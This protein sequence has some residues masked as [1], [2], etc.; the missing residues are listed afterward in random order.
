MHVFPNQVVKIIAPKEANIEYIERFIQSKSRWILK[1]IKVFEDIHGTSRAPLN[2]VSGETIYYLG[3][4]YRIKVVAGEAE[5]KLFQGRLVISVTDKE[6]KEKKE[7]LVES[8]YRKRQKEIFVRRLQYLYPLIAKYEVEFP[9]LRI[10]TM[11]KRWGS[12]STK[13]HRI[14]LNSELIYASTYCIDYVIV[15]E[16]V[17]FIH[18]NHSKQ[19]YEM[20]TLLMPDWK[21]RK[22]KLDQDVIREL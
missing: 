17:H 8:W 14:Q 6:D 4:Q 12:C 7:Q 21:E 16:L 11:E 13:T 9:N 19:F 3:R 5:T 20:L 2:Y 22:K 18:P 15:H 10:C 1:Q